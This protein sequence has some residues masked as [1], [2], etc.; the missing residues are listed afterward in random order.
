[1][2]LGLCAIIICVRR[3][4]PL[5][6]KVPAALKEAQHRD[7]QVLGTEADRLALLGNWIGA[8]PLY[9]EAG[10]IHEQ[11]GDERST[12]SSEPKQLQA[13]H[14]LL[15]RALYLADLYNWAD[16][17]PKFSESEKMF[18]AAGDKRNALYARLGRI[19]SNIEQH[20]L[21]ATSA[22][23]AAEFVGAT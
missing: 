7:P 13:A 19:R 10:Q 23:L 3:S 4:H 9:A 8:R 2:I 14:A 16:A 15:D 20:R 22:Q 18:V 21:P 5:H 17:A 12:R 11:G 6:R 1:M